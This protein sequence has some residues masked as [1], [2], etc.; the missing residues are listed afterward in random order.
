MSH[1]LYSS[2]ESLLDSI[3][4]LKLLDLE[5]SS[6]PTQKK[7]HQP[8]GNQELTYGFNHRYIDSGIDINYNDNLPSLVSTEF[9]HPY[10]NSEPKMSPYFYRHNDIE[11]DDYGSATL[12]SA[13]DLA[14]HIEMMEDTSSSKQFKFPESAFRRIETSEGPKYQCTYEGCQKSKLV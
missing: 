7:E 2:S 4:T 14:P 10:A 5:L 11:M 3:A 13:Q 1:H 9:R 8:F 12:G 6:L